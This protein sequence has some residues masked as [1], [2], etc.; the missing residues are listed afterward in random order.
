VDAILKA[1]RRSST[2]TVSDLEHFAERGGHINLL[3]VDQRVH[4]IVNLT[5]AEDCRLKISAKLL[6]LARIVGTTP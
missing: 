1:L 4:V 5:S 2:L 3:L 6:T